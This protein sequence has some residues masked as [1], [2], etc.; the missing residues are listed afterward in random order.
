[1]LIKRVITAAILVPLVVLGIFYLPYAYFGI[2]VAIILSLA[3]WEWLSLAGLTVMWQRILYI[4]LLWWGFSIAQL[5]PDMLVLWISFFWWLYA[6]Y[7]ILCYPNIAKTITN[8]WLV[9]CVMGFF[10]FIPCL[11]ALMLLQKR[12]P[13]YVL[14]VL[15][16]VWSADTGAYL[17]GRKWGKRKLS[18]QISPHKTIEGLLGG[19]GSA[20]AVAIIFG[21]ITRVAF[22]K[23]WLWAILVILVTL[24]AVIG[25]LFVSVL[26]R[27]AGVKDSG[28]WLPGHGGILDRIDSLTAAIPIFAL[29][30][31]IFT[32]YLL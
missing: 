1:L 7:L 31:L 12:S 17:I 5:L 19:I 18:P 14:F 20:M 24:F 13:L 26:K 28:Q 3:A 15:V 10:V 21:S 16:I 2:A 32:Q 25:D 9:R 23:W 27:L 29:G 22:S 6:F 30:L 8:K 4:G 11:Q